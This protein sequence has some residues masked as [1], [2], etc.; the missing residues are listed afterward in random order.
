MPAAR[1]GLVATARNFKGSAHISWSLYQLF[2]FTQNA[3][4]HVQLSHDTT[5]LMLTHEKPSF[6]HIETPTALRWCETRLE[7]G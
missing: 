1:A 4:Y 7:S 3:L 6:G 2:R 5:S